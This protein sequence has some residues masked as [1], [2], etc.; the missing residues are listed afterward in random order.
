MQ[1][2]AELRRERTARKL[3]VIGRDGI[4]TA[5]RPKG[6][7]KK[8]FKRLCKAALQALDD[9]DDAFEYALMRHLGK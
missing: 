5:K 2:V 8:T 4:Y 7:H 1:R 6:M 3:G 9:K